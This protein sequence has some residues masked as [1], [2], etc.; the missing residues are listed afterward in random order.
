VVSGLDSLFG[1]DSSGQFRRDAIVRIGGEPPVIEDKSEGFRLLVTG[2]RQFAG[3]NFTF[4]ALDLL[5]AELRLSAIVEGGALDAYS[6]SNEWAHKNDVRMQTVPLLVP[7]KLQG[8]RAGHERNAYMLTTHKPHA[9][10]VFPGGRGTLNME[11][12]ATAAGLP[13]LSATKLLA[14]PATAIAWL[15]AEAAPGGSAN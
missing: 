2:G 4:R 15:K 1:S 10:L 9:V 3:K 13:V 6:L 12:L 14:D 7:T 8:K 5:H 11:S